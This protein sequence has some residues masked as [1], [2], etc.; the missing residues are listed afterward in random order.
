MKYTVEFT[1]PKTGATSPIDNIEAPENYTAVQYVADCKAN[2][3]PEWVE[4]LESGDVSLVAD[5]V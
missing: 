1:D 3:D 2:A 5:D 4:M